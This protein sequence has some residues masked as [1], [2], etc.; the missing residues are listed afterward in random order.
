MSFKGTAH[1][2]LRKTSV[3]HNRKLN[4]LLNLLI[5][6]ISSST[7]PQILSLEDEYTFCF[8]NFLI[9]GF[10]N[11]SAKCWF[12]LIWFSIAD[13]SYSLSIVSDG[14][15]ATAW[16]IST[17]RLLIQT[18]INHWRKTSLISSYF[19]F[20]EKLNV[21]LLNTSSEVVLLHKSLKSP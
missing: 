20:L 12:D 7:A 3:I 16:S 17:R 8:S 15:H 13:L 1:A 21:L 6:C 18:F 10:C 19:R 9:I 2:C 5:N 4:P 11:F 14:A